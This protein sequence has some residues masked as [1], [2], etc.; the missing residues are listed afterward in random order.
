MLLS[1]ALV[2]TAVAS[3]LPG[4]APAQDP[5]PAQDSASQDSAAQDSAAQDPAAQ[6]P[7]AQDGGEVVIPGGARFVRAAAGMPPADPARGDADDTLLV[8]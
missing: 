1:A 3:P 2:M 7:A 5:V 8:E 4:A 6:E